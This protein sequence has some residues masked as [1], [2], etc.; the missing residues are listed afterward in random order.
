MQVSTSD[1]NGRNEGRGICLCSL[2][3]PNAQGHRTLK[4]RALY[5]R[6][7]VCRCAVKTSGEPERP[8]FRHAAS[9][10][11]LPS[12][13]QRGP[14][15]RRPGAGVPRD[16]RVDLTP[17]CEPLGGA[18][19]TACR[20]ELEAMRTNRCWS[21]SRSRVHLPAS[22]QAMRGRRVALPER[23]RQRG[24]APRGLSQGRPTQPCARGQRKATP[25]FRSLEEG[26]GDG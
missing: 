15:T 17:L 18:A 22:R 8:P 14:A 2:P 23:T 1:L 21:P 7:G 11:S 16:N 24:A 12:S 6:N 3:A 25:T 26:A 20:S 9:P 13:G 5:S 10:R 19:N 4:T